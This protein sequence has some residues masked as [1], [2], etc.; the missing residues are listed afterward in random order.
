MGEKG[1]SLTQ[2]RAGAGSHPPPPCIPEGQSSQPLYQE[3]QESGPTAGQP[4]CQECINPEWK[5]E[6]ERRQALHISPLTCSP[7]E[8]ELGRADVKTVP[9]G[10]FPGRDTSHRLACPQT[11][12]CIKLPSVVPFPLFTQPMRQEKGTNQ[13]FRDPT[14]PS[15]CLRWNS[16]D[17]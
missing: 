3:D 5:L 15:L 13:C 1:K 14:G 8:L 9:A 12:A 11:Q 17:G 16:V 6:G 7:L 4:S 10:V 2:A